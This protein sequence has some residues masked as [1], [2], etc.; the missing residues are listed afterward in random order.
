MKLHSQVVERDQFYL[1]GPQVVV[2]GEV[3]ALHENGVDAWVLGLR[4]PG[5]D[6]TAA[7]SRDP[8]LFGLDELRPY[9]PR[10]DKAYFLRRSDQ[11]LLREKW[12]VEASK[13]R[14]SGQVPGAAA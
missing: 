2:V 12:A 7:D 14:G 5:P 13:R 8:L 10:T 3:V 9:R 1:L 4:L 11:G 6:A